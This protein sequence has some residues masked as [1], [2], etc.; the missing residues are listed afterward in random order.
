MH[1][2][3]CAKFG[4]NHQ[5]ERRRSQNVLSS[6]WVRFQSRNRIGRALIGSIHDVRCFAMSCLR[7]L[8]TR[9]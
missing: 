2:N 6:F 7:Y 5:S 3:S 1:E 4:S 8:F 9:V